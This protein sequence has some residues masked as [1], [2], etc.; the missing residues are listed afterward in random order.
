MDFAVVHGDPGL[1]DDV[2]DGPR[3]Q[4]A[5]VHG[6][7]DGPSKALADQDHMASRLSL[8]NKARP[9]QRRNDLGRTEGGY[10]LRHVNV[11]RRL[12]QLLELLRYLEALFPRNGQPSRDGIIDHDER[13]LERLSVC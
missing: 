12:S 9:F 3:R 4:L 2:P 1:P 10:L 13:F 6:D 7:D 8:D 5:A 11:L